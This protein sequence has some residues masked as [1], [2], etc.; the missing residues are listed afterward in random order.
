M[1]TVVS[2]LRSDLLP[3]KRA[4]TVHVRGDGGSTLACLVPIVLSDHAL[5]TKASCTNSSDRILLGGE[6]GNSLEFGAVGRCIDCKAVVDHSILSKNSKLSCSISDRL[7]T[8]ERL[9]R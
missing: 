4:L 5:G 3:A 2:V 1:I 7:P 8:C 9:S 6:G